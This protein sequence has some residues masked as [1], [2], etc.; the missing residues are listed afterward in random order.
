YGGAP[1]LVHLAGIDVA[2]R[3]V[4]EYPLSAAYDVGDGDYPGLSFRVE[5]SDAARQMWSRLGGS[6]SSAYALKASSEYYARYSGISGI[7]DAQGGLDPARGKLFWFDV[8]LDT[9]GLSWL[10][11]RNV[12]SRTDGSVPVPGTAGVLEYWNAQFEAFD[13]AFVTEDPCEPSAEN[14]CLLPGVGMEARHL[15]LPL[16]G[17][18]GFDQAGQ[19]VTG[20]CGVM[21]EFPLPARFGIDG[22]VRSVGE[23]P[24]RYG[25]VPVRAAHLNHEADDT[26]PAGVDRV[27]YWNFAGGLDVAFFENLDVHLQTGADGGTGPS[28]IEFTGGWEEDGGSFFNRAR[29]DAGHRG[30]PGDAGIEDVD[31]YRESDAYLPHARQR[32][33]GLVDF[34]YPLRWSSGRRSFRSSEPR[35]DEFVVVSAEYRVDYLSADDLHIRFGHPS[36]MSRSTGT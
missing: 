33:L 27:G 6:D 15:G 31:D 32:W 19:I 12:D 3:T 35:T 2:D 20:R 10:S 7:Q 24:E 30:V 29:F 16:Y 8:E 13:L 11:N 34:D 5:G 18:I 4:L 26:R 23:A 28:V 21:S 22:P 17:T 1:S 9:F 14:L 25:S 36:L